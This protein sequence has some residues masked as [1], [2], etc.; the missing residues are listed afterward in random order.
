MRKSGIDRNIRMF[1]FGHS[2]GND[3]DFRYDTIDDSDLLTCVDQLE[4]FLQ[5]VDQNVDQNEKK[6]SN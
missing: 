5:N 4:D 1:I 2:N 6:L 3:M